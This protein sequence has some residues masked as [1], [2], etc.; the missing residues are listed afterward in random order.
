M[1]E[2]IVC[3]TL[4]FVAWLAIG[5]SA[6]VG[7]MIAIIKGNMN[8][9]WP[10]TKGTLTGSRLRVDKPKRASS[11]NK[12]PY[13][14]YSH[15]LEYSYVVDGKEYM[16]RRLRFADFLVPLAIRRFALRRIEKYRRDQKLMFIMSPQIPITH[17]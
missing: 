9:S 6:L 4:T 14:L 17:Q 2:H 10:T 16:E 1:I 3:D 5:L 15:D 13:P 7:G 11:N 8:C 12:R